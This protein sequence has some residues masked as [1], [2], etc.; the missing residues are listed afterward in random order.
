[1]STENIEPANA[2]DSLPEDMKNEPVPLNF[3][4]TIADA[5]ESRIDYNFNSIIQI[6]MLVEY[7]YS[8]LSDHGITI[9]LEEDFKSFQENRLEEIQ[10][11]FQKVKDS[12]NPDQAAQEF[13]GTKVN[14][15]DD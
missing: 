11:E 12:L 8:K 7:L 5:L 14:L 10:S 3:L 13:M 15:E 1:M 4:I 9:E 6:S 2:A